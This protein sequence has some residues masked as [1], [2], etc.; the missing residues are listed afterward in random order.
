MIIRFAIGFPFFVLARLLAA[1]FSWLTFPF[2]MCMRARGPEN[3]ST[4]QLQ[5]FL[6]S[7]PAVMVEF[8]HPV[9]QLASG[10]NVLMDMMFAEYS[11]N[12]GDVVCIKSASSCCVDMEQYHKRH[13]SDHRKQ[14]PL[15]PSFF[16]MFENGQARS[17]S[18]GYSTTGDL[19]NMSKERTVL[20][21]ATPGG[22]RSV[23]GGCK[24]GKA[25]GPSQ[26]GQKE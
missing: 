26:P 24:L 23:G 12:S 6:A 13:P 14:D 11:R 8:Y 10:M 15:L 4:A 7:K 5:E 1:L 3:I 21:A 25:G 17:F 20:T 18:T 9:L 2:Y 16:V 19:Q 22:P